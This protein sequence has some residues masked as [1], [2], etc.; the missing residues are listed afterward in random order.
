M[1]NI[2][3][4]YFFPLGYVVGRVGQ[5]CSVSLARVN[6]AAVWGVPYYGLIA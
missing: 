6:E 3:S 1:T 5:T 2:V 4:E